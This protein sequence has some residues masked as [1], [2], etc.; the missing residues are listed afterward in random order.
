VG[1]VGAAIGAG[2]GFDCCGVGTGGMETGACE[3]CDAVG[4]FVASL[5]GAA[6][7]VG[8]AIMES[9]P[10]FSCETFLGTGIIFARDGASFLSDHPYSRRNTIPARQSAKNELNSA[11]TLTSPFDLLPFFRTKLSMIFAKGR[12]REYVEKQAHRSADDW[13]A[14]ASGGRTEGGRCG[15]RGGRV[16]AHALRL[17]GEV[18]RDGCEPGAGS[19]ATA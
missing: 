1:L 10:T 5:V 7:A 13:G 12:G 15:A 2:V 17:E 6:T 19:E 4:G 3:I 18:R 9:G 8:G 16:Q 14:K 11:G